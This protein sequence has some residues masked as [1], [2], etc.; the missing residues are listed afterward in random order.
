MVTHVRN[1]VTI[2][3]IKKR[4]KVG[5]G[6]VFRQIFTTFAEREHHC[7]RFVKATDM[8]HRIGIY[9]AAVVVGLMILAGC[10]GGGTSGKRVPQ[11]S[12]SL[13]T[14]ERAMAIYDT[15]PE[16]ALQ[17][18]DS[19]EIVGNMP[20]YRAALF[21]AKVLSSSYVMMQQDS[22]IIICEALLRHDEAQ[23]NVDFRQD[24][25]ELLLNASRRR[26]DYEEMVHWAAELAELLRG[27][28]LETEALRT[29]ADLG[30]ALTHIGQTDE[31]LAKIDNAIR[32]LGSTKK[33]NELDAWLIAVKRKITVLQEQG[34][35]MEQ[36]ITLSD[37][38]QQRLDDFAAHADDY[39]D[40]TYREPAKDVIPGYHDLYHAQ[41]TGY[42]ASAYAA[43]GDRQAAR[44]EMDTFLRSSY[45]QTLD[46]R[47]SVAPTMAALGDYAAMLSTYDEV[48]RRMLSEGDTLNG[49]YASILRGRAEAASASGHA[50]Q[51]YDYLSRYEALE[52]QLNDRLQR[53]K[54]H[55][56]A[57]RY[58][59]QEQ[60]L[61][62]QQRKSEANRN[63]ILAVGAII[64]ALLAAGFAVYYFRQQRI[65]R[66]KNR[67]L[68]EQM[69]E[70]LIYK[71]RYESQDTPQV[72]QE[73][74]PLDAMA[75]D[76]LSKHLR[77]VILRERLYLSAQF[78]RQAA[79]D[80]FHLSKE[81]I[82]AAFSQDSEYATIADFI[83]HCRLEYARDLLVTSPDMTV[84]DIA[85]ASGFGTRRT[86]SRLFKERYSVTPTEFR[87]QIV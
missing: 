22:A 40:G 46:G 21:R 48:E 45:G 9:V 4:L 25:L 81:R 34:T 59:A 33:F 23:R 18:L 56:Y 38:M 16:R 70:A 51:A 57:A 20:D 41:A 50:V 75:P 30:L 78:D 1:L 49:V 74:K 35:Q 37:L 64:L 12:D 73:D 58:H 66:K 80:Y 63:L 29:D 65:I 8:K 69:N 13:Y 44:R 62:I 43:L 26:Y 24:V 27:Q 67:V 17:I 68:V 28:G 72:P 52:S 10:T 76:E 2:L 82:G 84:D 36:V 14:E 47:N 87:N 11:A 79:I 61:E 55:L 42:K 6:T 53:S 86:F 3:I 31:G 39:H 54:A 7:T 77:A 15:L 60:Q 85:S 32:Q 71:K 83:N 5:L 19:A